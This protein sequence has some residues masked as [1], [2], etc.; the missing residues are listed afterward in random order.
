MGLKMKVPLSGPDITQ[1]EIDAV[2]DVMRSGILSIGPKLEEFEHKIAEYIGVKHAVGVNSGTSGLHLLVRSM[3]ISD[4]DEVITTPFSFISSSNCILFERAKPVFVDIDPLTLNMDIDRIE[5]KISER[6]KAILA[7]DV[8]GQ[9]MDIAKVRTITDKYGLKLIEDSC[10]ALG[11]EYNGVKAGSRADAAVFAFYP[12]KQMTTAEGGMIVT[13]DDDIAALCRSM[14]SQGRPITGLWLE[15][16][17]LGYNYRLSELHAALGCVQIGRI[18]EIIDK[19]NRVA[20][21]YNNMLKDID[22]VTL[23]YISPDVNKM[24]W[25]I[26]FVRLDK[27]IDRNAV[28]QYL[29]DNGIGCRPYFT[30]IHLQPYFR[31]MFGY[32]EGDFPLTEGV[33]E[34]TVALPFF[35]NLSDE[36]MDYTV[37]NLKRAIERFGR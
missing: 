15:H 20:Q 34:S 14:R 18:E 8:F 16:E 5:D 29:L 1:K 37:Y 35:N 21:R 26:Y 24:S 11:S 6:T 32:K 9:P 13:D 28:M 4:D 31:D 19:R 10:E 25:F 23:P 33:A 3:E 30:P 27:R 22:G 36:Q 7:V 12:N 17:R 2:M